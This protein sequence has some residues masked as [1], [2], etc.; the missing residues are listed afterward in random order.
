MPSDFN[1][2]PEQEH[3]LLLKAMKTILSSGRIPQGVSNELIMVAIL[4]MNGSVRR[5][6]NQ[7]RRNA[8]ALKWLGAGIILIVASIAF[9]HGDGEGSLVQ[10]VGRF[11]GL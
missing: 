8:H 5:T 1:P 11:L 7:S 9:L 3:S 6:T 10:M 4:E 2:L